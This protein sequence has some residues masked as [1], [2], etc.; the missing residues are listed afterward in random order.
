MYFGEHCHPAER[1]CNDVRVEKEYALKTVAGLG[2][3]EG[4]RG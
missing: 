3:E 1:H 4:T 2:P